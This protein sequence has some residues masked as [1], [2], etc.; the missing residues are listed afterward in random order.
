MRL[1]AVRS[2]EVDRL[3]ELRLRALRDDPGAFGS[4]YEDEVGREPSHWLRWVTGATTFVVD[5]GGWHGLVAVYLDGDDASI[6]HLGSMWVDARQ[7]GRGLGHRL[8]AAGIDWAREAG[9]AS[10]RLGV[11]D[12]NAAAL[13]VY[14]RAGFEPTGEREPLRSDPTKSVVFMARP[15]VPDQDQG[16]PAE[17]SSSSPPGGSGEQ[18]AAVARPGLGEH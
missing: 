14:R 11:V 7:R 3:K 17:I 9:A 12:G 4:R 15:L 2:D 10:I 13:G 16:S 6:C 1:R 18:G 8:L 5:D